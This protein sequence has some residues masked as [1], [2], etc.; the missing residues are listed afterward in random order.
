MIAAAGA[1]GALYIAV[2]CGEGGA[3]WRVERLDSTTGTVAQRTLHLPQLRTLTPGSDGL[4]VTTSMVDK[5][6]TKPDTILR[7]D[8]TTLQTLKERRLDDGAI[9]DGNVEVAASDSVLAE[10]DGGGA[11]RLLDP[12]T[13][14]TKATIQVL[15]K[16]DLEAGDDIGS[17]VM[18]NGRL[19][20]LAKHKIQSFALPSLRRI[21]T[22]A[23]GNY[24]QILAATAGLVV[25]RTHLALLINDKVTML[26][27]LPGSDDEGGMRPAIALRNLI[28]EQ[29]DDLNPRI[30]V[31]QLDGHLLGAMQ[32]EAD[33]G[34]L[35]AGT[36]HLLWAQG[37]GSKGAA[38]SA[39]RVG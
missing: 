4:Y 14:A 26:P 6:G 34:L 15:T 39:I 12:R 36:D 3:D 18:R 33:T 24:T 32:L 30:L 1:A 20:V 10:V 9:W 27:G 37:V 17:P 35:L 25:I 11:I 22:S 23:E 13:L 8:P 5:Y 7:L 21:S 16:S 31:R 19:W 28:A 2:D 38:I 29:P